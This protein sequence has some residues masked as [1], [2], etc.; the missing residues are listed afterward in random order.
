MVTVSEIAMMSMNYFLDVKWKIHSR[1]K[2]FGFLWVYKKWHK[3]DLIM[4]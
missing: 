4:G 2:I 3:D 1:D